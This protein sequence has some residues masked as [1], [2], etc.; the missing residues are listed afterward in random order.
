MACNADDYRRVWE[1]A[2]RLFKGG[3]DYLSPH[4]EVLNLYID[5]RKLAAAALTVFVI[6]PVAAGFLYVGNIFVPGL[7]KWY[8][9]KTITERAREYFETRCV[10]TGMTLP[11]AKISIALGV[12]FYFLIRIAAAFPEHLV[13]DI[14]GLSIAFLV[15]GSIGDLCAGNIPN[16]NKARLKYFKRFHA[17]TVT[18]LGLALG[19]IALDFIAQGLIVGMSY[20]KGV[21]WGVQVTSM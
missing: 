5:P 19:T 6:I 20:L 14:I 2:G 10:A 9:D 13:I 16:S 17:P 8:Y 3:V 15:I 11:G 4:F 18:G 12:V 7:I 1:Y 21:A